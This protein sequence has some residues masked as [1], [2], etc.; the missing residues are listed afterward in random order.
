M[1][2]EYI[3]PDCGAYWDGE[4]TGD[5]KEGD[6]IECVG[7]GRVN[8]I[9]HIAHKFELKKTAKKVSPTQIEKLEQLKNKSED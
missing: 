7:C 8:K 4:T 2:Y 6:T 9:H 5:Y 1:N 3:C